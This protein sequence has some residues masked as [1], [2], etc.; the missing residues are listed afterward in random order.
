MAATSRQIQQRIKTAQSI[1]KITKAMEMV[2]ASKM[3]KAQDRALSAR[4][5]DA[6]LS[7]ALSLLAASSSSA[8]H[9]L[10]QSHE[11]GMPIAV[12]ISTDRGLCGSLN[13]NLLK[14][15]LKWK[16]ENENGQ[17]IVVGKKAVAFCSFFGIPIH[18]Q[19]TDLPDSVSSSDI[20]PLSTLLIQGYLDQSFTDVDIFFMDFVNTLTQK[21]K[22]AALLPL[23]RLSEQQDA[24][25][26]MTPLHAEYVFEPS[27]QQ[28]LDKLLPYYLENTIYQAFLEARASE[29]SARMVTMKNASDNA[30]ELVDDLKLLYNKQRQSAI[31]SELLDITTAMLSLTN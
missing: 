30:N 19:F 27:P 5:Y 4:P 11:A 9:P 8:T 18:A 1:R 29:H 20:V 21:P 16:V 7:Q 2:S 24:P 3:R 13:Q 25:Q 12:I 6:A 31:T 15:V 23:S 28:I 10:M 22:T 17:A 14:A 26:N